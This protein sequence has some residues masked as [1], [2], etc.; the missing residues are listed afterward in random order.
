MARV[1][2]FEMPSND[3]Q[4]SK[5]FYE[6]VFDWKLQ[7]WDGPMEYWLVST[8]ERNEPGIDGALGGGANGFNATVNTISVDNLDETLR[9]VLANG[10]QVIQPKDEIPG[11]G[12]VAYVREPGGAVMGVIQMMPGAMM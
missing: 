1:V 4:A 12:W 6:Q 8:G 10:G 2:H 7:K 9:K 5:K 11:V 3:F